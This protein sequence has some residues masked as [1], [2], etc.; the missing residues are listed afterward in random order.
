MAPTNPRLRLPDAIVRGETIE[1]R[2]LVTHVME[3][4]NR[5]DPD[6]NRIPRNIINTFEARFD[7]ALVFKA[8]FG[9]G[10]SANPFLAFHLKVSHPGELRVTWKADDGSAAEERVMIEVAEASPP[11]EEP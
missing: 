3:T 6:G 8:E 11:A 4:G 10:I 1:V 5:R 7:G 2:A 9:S